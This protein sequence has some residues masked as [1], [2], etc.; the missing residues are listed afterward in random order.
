MATTTLAM[1]V[2]TWFGRI[3]ENHEVIL[4]T[5]WWQKLRYFH[6]GSEMKEVFEQKPELMTELR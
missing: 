5:K 4:T 1:E 3:Q 6:F 2:K